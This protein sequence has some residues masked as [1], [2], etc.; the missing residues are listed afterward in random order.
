MERYFT[1]LTVGFATSTIPSPTPVRSVIVPVEIFKLSRP[2]VEIARPASTSPTKGARAMAAETRSLEVS[3]PRHGQESD[4]AFDLYT[5][6]S[7][8]S[9]FFPEQAEE[10]QTGSAH[11]VARN[12]VHRLA[13]IRRQV[14]LTQAQIADRM[15]VRQERVSAIERAEPGTTEIRTLTAYVEALGGRLEITAD[16][17]GERMVLG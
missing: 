5:K 12:R 1:N 8:L 9:E 7:F 13:E 14:G 11:L 16:L 4:T 3:L 10:V 2:D 15:N 6:E 17:G